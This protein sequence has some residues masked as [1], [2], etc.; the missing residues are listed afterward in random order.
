MTVAREL[1]RRRVAGSDPIWFGGPELEFCDALN[2][3][4]NTSRDV[5]QHFD[6]LAEEGACA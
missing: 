2:M 4:L 1:K 3:P 6:W 5:L